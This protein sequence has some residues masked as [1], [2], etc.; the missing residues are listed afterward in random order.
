MVGEIGEPRY[1]Q[2]M[3]LLLSV[4]ARAGKAFLTPALPSALPERRS[5]ADLDPHCTDLEGA[6]AI[7]SLGSRV[8]PEALRVLFFR[9]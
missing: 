5:S 8:N 1:T 6:L 7:P 3:L 4:L 9:Q 2:R